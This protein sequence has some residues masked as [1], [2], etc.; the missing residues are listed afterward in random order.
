MKASIKIGT[1][2]LCF[3]I[4]LAL[5]GKSEATEALSPSRI[6]LPKVTVAPTVTEYLGAEPRGHGLRISGFRQREPNDG[7]P[8]ILQTVAYLSYDDQNIY[9]IFVCK[10]DRNAIRAHMSR[11]EDIL[12]DDRVSIFIDTFH[13][14]RRAYEF[15]ANPLG[16]QRDGIITEGQDDDFDFDGVWSSEGKLTDDGFLVRFAIPFKSLRF[17][18]APGA[19]WGIALGR[20]SPAT[21]EFSTWPHLTQKI[22]AYVSQFAILEAI[23]DAPSVHNLQLIPH[24]FFAGQQFLNTSG[25]APA[26]QRQN[27]WRGGVDGKFV[28]R[29]ALT[30]DFTVNPDFSQVE[31]DEPQVT[32]NQRYEVFFPEKR[33]FFT[34]G[35]GFFATPETLF[36]SRRVIDPQFGLRMSGKAGSWAFGMLTMDDRAPG[37]L[38]DRADPFYGRRADVGVFRVLRDVGKESTVGLF[39]SRRHFTNEDNEVF[40]FDTRLKLSPNWIFTG[41][42][43]RSSAKDQSGRLSGSGYFAEIRRSGLHLN[44][45]TD[46]LDRSPDFRAD[47]GFIPRVDMRQIRSMVRYQWRPER[48][49]LVNFGPSLQTRVVW[50][51]RGQMEGWSVETPFSFRFKGPTS[52]TVGRLEECE[53]FQ[54]LGFRENA[55]YI[56]LSTQR[57]HWFGIDAS[58]V[59]GSNINFAPA[60]GIRAFL[61]TSDDASLGLTFRPT[62]RIQVHETYLY[63]RLGTLTRNAITQAAPATSV[64]NNHLLRTKI[65]YQVTKALSLRTIVDYDAVLPNS[66]LSSLERSKKITTDVLV[67]YLLNPGTAIYA[68]YSDRRENLA[69]DPFGASSL[70]RTVSPDLLTGRQFFVKA[71]YLLRF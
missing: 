57:L 22:D 50:D 54:A 59:H 45:S 71:S 29:D 7:S 37:L 38:R 52:I 34:E 4:L 48:G 30:F 60:E 12:D 44:Y 65:S 51:Y 33:P 15:F 32:V 61:G 36:F 47:L 31:S 42:A 66:S 26:S 9:A 16:V 49:A 6:Q 10:G 24:V 8:A 55:S 14:G 5:H 25:S 63:D 41:Q 20:Y 69:L 35:A 56:Y 70:R 11:R 53:T 39:V 1:W 58:F 17:T 27:E 62:S 19:T 2:V 68:G 21:K 28:M 67:T 40:S 3:A 23:G 18:S 64:F 43:T 46:Y 13:D